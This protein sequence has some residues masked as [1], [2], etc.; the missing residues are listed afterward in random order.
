MDVGAVA[1]D[2]VAFGSA[3]V[4]A[5]G[6]VDVVV[7]T[8]VDVAGVVVVTGFEEDELQAA[9]RRRRATKSTGRSAL[10]RCTSFTP[11]R[12][13]AAAHLTPGW[14]ASDAGLLS[15]CCR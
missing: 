10:F 13:N 1:W 5:V 4:A 3:V 7:G 14:S 2:V 12:R 11:E 9:P 6:A 15:T 8:A